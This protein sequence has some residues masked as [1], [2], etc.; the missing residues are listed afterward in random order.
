[1]THDKATTITIPRSPCPRQTRLPPCQPASFITYFLLSSPIRFFTSDLFSAPFLFH[2]S[3]HP[4][5]SIV[6]CKE[7]ISYSPLSTS[8]IFSSHPA[9]P[10]SPFLHSSLRYLLVLHRKIYCNLA[11]EKVRH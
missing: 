4:P 11:E 6:F 1:L 2:K 7:T 10:N 9:S 8:F 5:E 3:N